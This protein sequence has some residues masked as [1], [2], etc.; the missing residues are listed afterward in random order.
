MLF[1]LMAFPNLLVA[2][3]YKTYFSLSSEAYEQL[4][5]GNADSCIIIY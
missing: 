1:L 5:R 3:N 2:Q 4:K